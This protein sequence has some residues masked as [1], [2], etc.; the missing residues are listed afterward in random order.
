M[1]YI[2]YHSL[3]NKVH[4]YACFL[5]TLICKHPYYVYTCVHIETCACACVFK[6]ICVE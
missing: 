5:L 1:V 6:H 3:H 4:N 2:L